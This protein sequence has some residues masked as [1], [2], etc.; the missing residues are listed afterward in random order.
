MTRNR[1]KVSERGMMHA[2]TKEFQPY[3]M[4]EHGLEI[5]DNGWYDLDVSLQK[6]HPSAWGGSG[7]TMPLTVEFRLQIHMADLERD[8]SWYLHRRAEELGVDPTELPAR[9][10]LEESDEETEAYDTARRA[11][12]EA[13]F[14]TIMRWSHWEERDAPDGPYVPARPATR[15]AGR[16]DHSDDFLFEVRGFDH[17]SLG[18]RDCARRDKQGNGD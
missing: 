3:P 7:G 12:S 15:R 14:M 9:A 16:T 2:D 18:F 11:V 13:L 17:I 5:I 1:K 4:P 6:D 8:G 10:T